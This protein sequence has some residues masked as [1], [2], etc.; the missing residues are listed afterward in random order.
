MQYSRATSYAGNCTTRTLQVV[1]PAAG[2][3][4]LPRKPPSYE[5]EMTTAHCADVARHERLRSNAVD[6]TESAPEPLAGSRIPGK[7]PSINVC[8]PRVRHTITRSSALA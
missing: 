4:R 7:E 2:W 5:R 6:R 8:T 1:A 3:V